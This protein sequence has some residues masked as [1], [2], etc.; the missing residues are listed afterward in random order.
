MKKVNMGIALGA[1]CAGCDVAILDLNEKILPVFD[2]VEFKFWPTAMDFKL[3]DLKA[4]KAKELDVGIYH[5]AIRTEED[6]EIAEILREKAKVIVAFGA[7]ANFGGIPSLSDLPF[8]ENMFDVV[9]KDVPSMDNPEGIVPLV[10]TTVDGTEL[11]LPGIRKHA[12]AL[13]SVIDVDYWV[14]GCPPMVPLIEQL[15]EVVKV[16]AT[17]GE[18]PPKGTVIAGEKTLC[19]ECGREKPEQILLED[20]ITAQEADKI[21]PDKCLLS[22]G[23][24]CMGPATRAGCGG[25]C[26]HRNVGCRG[27]MGGTSAVKDQGLKMISALTSMIVLDKEENLGE[28]RLREVVNKIEDPLGLFYRFSFGKSL[29]S[30]LHA[31]EEI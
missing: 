21:D 14:P 3:D 30:Q 15:I 8:T 11:T 20:F 10:K 29:I 22:Q 25:L 31:E 6:K 27:C 26:T 17:T 18:L 1:T 23:I 5:G 24:L 13:D 9:Y 7:C 28:E 19:E 16:Y 12:K 4:L 2:L